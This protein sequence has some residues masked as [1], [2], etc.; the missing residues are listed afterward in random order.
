MNR[1]WIVL[2]SGCWHLEK[3]GKILHLQAFKDRWGI[4]MW[5]FQVIT[6]GLSIN[7]Q[8]F[9]FLGIELCEKN[10][11]GILHHFIFQTINV[12]VIH[13]SSSYRRIPLAAS[14]FGVNSMFLYI[15]RC[16]MRQQLHQNEGN[17]ILGFL[18]QCSTDG[19]C[20]MDTLFRSNSNL[21]WH[22]YIAET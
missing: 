16:K 21:I 11:I 7:Q 14:L 17:N 12:Y 20:K 15:C 8:Q 3:N 1:T 4:E 19:V 18:E 5:N 22:K 10:D 6:V 9:I 13:K 2:S